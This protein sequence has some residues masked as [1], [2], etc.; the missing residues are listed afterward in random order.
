MNSTAFLGSKKIGLEILKTMHRIAPQALSVI[1]ALDDRQDG[2]SCLDKFCDF[3]ASVDKPLR[4]ISKNADLEKVIEEFRPDFCMVNGYYRILK[5]DLLARFPAGCMGIHGS[6][7]PK[8]RGGSPLVWSILNG[9]KQSGIS[10]FYFDDG[11]D[12]GDLIGQ[13]SYT[14]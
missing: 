8:Y 4:V 3:A 2:R 10:L 1:M 11:M 5:P 13:R 9:D 6:L 7:L 12:T 14:I